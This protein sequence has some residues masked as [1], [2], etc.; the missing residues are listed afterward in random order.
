MSSH[1]SLRVLTPATR[2][3]SN[4]A[5]LDLA[6]LSD[7]D[8]L[9]L[10]RRLRPLA[11]MLQA[12]EVRTTGAIDS[13][14]V[15]L[16][17]G[18]RSTAVWLRHGLR[19]SDASRR[20][21]CAKALTRMPQV[22]RAF[23]DGEISIEHV[24]LA[25]RVI[26]RLTDQALA[27]GADRE[28]VRRAR[29]LTPRGFARAATVIADESGDHSQP[30][31]RPTAE[32]WLDARRTADGRVVITGRFS[33]PEGDRLIEGLDAL[34][35][36]VPGRMD[37]RD[38]IAARRADALLGL[39]IVGTGRA[40][41]ARADRMSGRPGVTVNGLVDGSSRNGDR[42]GQTVSRRKRRRRAQARRPN[43]HR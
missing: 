17:H 20:I 19:V 3:L 30:R 34:V 23:V 9:E 37:D 36:C 41:S 22:A 25:A 5:R 31:K 4:L 18:S 16:S 21:R 2:A 10:A 29:E 6:I 35:P 43:R 40:R 1:D 39:L 13:R 14:G 12:M 33:S 28:M 26:P 8:L 42:R 11:C 24:D 27:G 15:A 32:R 38:S 7:G